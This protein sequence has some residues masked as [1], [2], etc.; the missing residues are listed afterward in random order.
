[1]PLDEDFVK[2][3]EAFCREK[4][5]LLIIDEVQTGIGRTGC[6]F[7]YQQYEIKPDVVTLAK[8]LGGGLP[9]GAVMAAKNCCNVLTPGTHA[10]TFGGTPTV[11][12]AVNV[13]LDTVVDEHFLNNVFYKGEYLR[14]AILSFGS[15]NIHDVR[16]MGLMLGIVVDEGRH[17]EFATRLIEKGVLV[18]TAGNNAVRLLPPLTITLQEMDQ[19]LRIMKE[20]F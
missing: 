6:L 19:A 10:S 13:V 18:L 3:V 7:C 20:V 1:L 16:G 15:K 4:D 11:C 2:K 5:L 14:N 17:T 8:G 9:V 12:A